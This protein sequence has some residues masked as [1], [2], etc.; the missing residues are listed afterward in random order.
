LQKDCNVIFSK[1]S[2]LVYHMRNHS[3]QKPYV[4]T[5]EGCGMKFSREIALHNHSAEHA[6][7]KYVCSTPGCHKIFQRLGRFTYHKKICKF[8][9]KIEPQEEWAT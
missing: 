8:Q 3:E 9:V 4:C 5:H 6:R 1:A 7:N 2:D